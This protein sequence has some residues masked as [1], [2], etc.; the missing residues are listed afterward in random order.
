MGIQCPCGPLR[1]AGVI[2][3]VG[4]YIGV[5]ILTMRHDLHGLGMKDRPTA[6]EYQSANLP[7]LLIG[8]GEQCR[9]DNRV[10]ALVAPIYTRLETDL[11]KYSNLTDKRKQDLLDRCKSD[12]CTVVSIRGG[13]MKVVQVGAGFQTRHSDVLE[14]LRRV[15]EKF[16]PLPDVD[17]VVDTG[18]GW[19]DTN[20]LPRFMMCGHVQAPQGIMVPDFTFYDYPAASCPGEPDRKFTSFIRNTTERLQKLAADPNGVVNGRENKVFWRGANLTNPSRMQNL[21]AILATIPAE[22]DR[23]T[24]DLALMEWIANIGEGKNLANGCVSM[25]DH[26]TRR[27]LLHLRG[28]TY[29]SRLKFLLMCG[30]VVFMPQQEYEEWWSPAVSSKASFADEVG[31]DEPGRVIAHVKEDVSDFHQVFSSFYTPSG[32][33]A[34]QKTIDTSL[35]T[36]RFAADVFSEQNVLCYWAAVIQGAA[37]AWGTIL[38]GNE[39]R[40]RLIDD[41]LRDNIGSFSDL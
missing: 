23:S 12:I 38:A 15:G 9:F 41:V 21:E 3:A 26:C 14:L 35:R 34:S 29:S 31:D 2:C 33:P 27:F 6:V 16:Y 20:Q 28:N 10:A 17:F 13:V 30:S 24:Y 8:I 32:Q 36:I 5:M 1:T 25:N 11:R 22:A 40:G 7:G 18:D 4:L 39:H 19:Y 37:R